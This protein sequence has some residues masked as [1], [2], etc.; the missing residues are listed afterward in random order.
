MPDQQAKPI[1]IFYAYAR[2][3]GTLRNTLE[4][5]LSALK[6]KGLITTC[7]DRDITAGE[8]WKL[9][10]DKHLNEAQVILLLISPEFIASEYCYSIEMQ[11]ALK[12]HKQREAKVI[13]VILR[14][15]GG[16]ENVPPGD[17]QL[18]DLQA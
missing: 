3:D 18:G 16:W 7:Y 1:E 14:P 8:K 13:P 15:I 2:K 11:H 5:H 4:T 17:I 12:R 9:E 10:I 6:R